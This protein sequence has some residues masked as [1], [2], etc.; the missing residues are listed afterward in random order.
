VDPLEVL[1]R[2]KGIEESDAKPKR[3]EKVFP[4]RVFHRRN[5]LFRISRG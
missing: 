2:A 5:T 3:N 1:E 4:E